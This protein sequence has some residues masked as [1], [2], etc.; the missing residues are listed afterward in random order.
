MTMKE[1]KHLNLAQRSVIS[2]LKASGMKQKK[3]RFMRSVVPLPLVESWQE[4]KQRQEN[5]VQ[6]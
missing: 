5:T 1:Y 2:A 4:T 3:L 6:K